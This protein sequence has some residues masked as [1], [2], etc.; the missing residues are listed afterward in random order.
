MGFGVYSL[1][2][3]EALEN[4]II[5]GGQST[6]EVGIEAYYNFAITPWLQFSAALQ[7][8]ASDIVSNDDAV[9][10]GTR[11]FAQF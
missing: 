5:I 2:A 10:S 7:W 3:S 4:Q 9:V 1:I 11:I 8:V 6:N